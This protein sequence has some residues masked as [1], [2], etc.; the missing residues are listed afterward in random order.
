MFNPL[1]YEIRVYFNGSRVLPKDKILIGLDL[2]TGHGIQAA[3]VELDRM[4]MRVAAA[5]RIRPKDLKYCRV[6]VLYEET[7]T[8]VCNHYPPTE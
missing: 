1:R 2:S 4:L 3:S 8:V 7:R 5:A 6:E